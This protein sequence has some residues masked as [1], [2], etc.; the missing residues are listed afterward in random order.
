[1]Q[2]VEPGSHH[3]EVRHHV[4]LA[5][6]VVEPVHQLD[7]FGNRANLRE[8]CPRLGGSGPV[9]G[10]AERFDLRGRLAAALLF[11][12]DV[13][14][15]VGVE[16]RIE[17][18]QIDGGAREVLL[19]N[20]EVVSVVQRIHAVKFAD[21]RRIPCTEEGFRS[22]ALRPTSSRSPDKSEFR[23]ENIIADR[24]ADEEAALRASLRIA[25]HRPRGAGP[26]DLSD[27]PAG[28]RGQGARGRGLGRSGATDDGPAVSTVCATNP[29][30]AFA[31]R[32]VEATR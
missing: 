9:P 24:L 8:A 26:H 3:H 25:R 18:D 14:I 20:V 7:H 27:R 12:Q 28:H 10:I 22:L 5:N 32:V 1:M 21:G 31:I 13:V 11:E 30:P 29:A 19:E 15:A 2:V 23:P 6:R 17:V 4:V 16:R